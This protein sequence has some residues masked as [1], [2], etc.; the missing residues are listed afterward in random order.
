M[1]STPNSEKIAVIGAKGFL[2]SRVFGLLSQRGH[3]VYPFTRESPFFFEDLNFF[4]KFTSVVW[5]ATSVNPIISISDEGANRE[6]ITYWSRFLDYSCKLRECGFS[7]RIIFLSSGGC[8]YPDGK[9]P[10]NEDLDGVPYNTYGAVKKEMERLALVNMLN[11]TILRL[12]NVYGPSQPIGVGQGVIAE[13]VHKVLRGLPIEVYGNLDAFRDFSYVDDVVG[14][15]SLAIDSPEP[16]I[17]NI[18]GGGATTLDTL[19]RIIT[20]TSRISPQ[21][22]ISPSRKVDR[23]GYWLDISKIGN[24]LGWK[25]TTPLNE[26]IRRVVE[27]EKKLL[28]GNS[29]T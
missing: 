14:A 25:P 4:S 18:G 17:Y 15:I 28:G 13:W 23:I 22:R 19:L 24:N 9:L 6:E 10:F 12:S 27:F 29:H 16:S 11:L 5:C 26:G 2:G 21:V 7:P 20:E 8:V 1:A 3:P